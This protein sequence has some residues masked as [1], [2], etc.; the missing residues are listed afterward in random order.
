M[1]KSSD[2]RARPRPRQRRVFGEVA[3]QAAQDGVGQLVL[4]VFAAQALLF[5]GVADEGGFYQDAGDV[6]GLEHSKAGL[7]YLRFMRFGK[8]F[9][10]SQLVGLT[11]C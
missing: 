10:S 4:V 3:L 11:D 1:N 5:F 7:L 6:G 2:L 8:V 9:M